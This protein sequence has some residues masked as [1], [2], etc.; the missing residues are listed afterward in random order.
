M[1]KMEYSFGN[2][3]LDRDEVLHKDSQIQ[4]FQAHAGRSIFV[5]FFGVVNHWITIIVHKS[6]T[7][8]VQVYAFDST[9][10]QHMARPDEELEQL[11]LESRCWKKIRVGLK[12]TS[13]FMC[14][15]SIQ[16]LFDQRIF[17]TKFPSILDV[18]DS[19]TLPRLHTSC[20]VNYMLKEFHHMT[21]SLNPNA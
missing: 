10:I 15:M 9:N 3:F 6:S 14:E 7:G 17:Y 20:Q 16:S 2:L 18:E 5:C 8:A 13:R 12:P 19:L 21:E 11:S 4:A 1:S